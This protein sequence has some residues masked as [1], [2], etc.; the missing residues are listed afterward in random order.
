M[1]SWH[2]YIWLKRLAPLV[3]VLLIWG[4]YV[5]VSNHLKDKEYRADR[6]TA[7]VTA[8]L[9]IGSAKYRDDPERY[10][11][12]RDSLLISHGLSIE[13][14]EH[15]TDQHTDQPEKYRQFSAM[16]A[17]LVDSLYKMEDSLRRAGDENELDSTIDTT[18][19]TQIP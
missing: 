12:Y 6:E 8:Q 5:L 18:S 2:L 9:W 14:V 13:A 15:F 4:G 3:I 11:S 19:G 7:L 16:V 17:V 1:K 10:L